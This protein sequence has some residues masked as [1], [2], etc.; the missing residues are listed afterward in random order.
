MCSADITLES[1][2][3]TSSDA[4][5]AKNNG[6]GGNTHG[7]SASTPLAAV[8][9]WGATH[10]CRDFGVVRTWAEYHRA[11]DDAGID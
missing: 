7:R 9:G 6:G 5:A 3:E 2:Q 11:S 4:S 10:L 8:D 1:L